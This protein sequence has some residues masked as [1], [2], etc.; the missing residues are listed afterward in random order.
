LYP[1]CSFFVLLI[2]FFS[3]QFIGEF[4]VGPLWG[5]DFSSWKIAAVSLITALSTIV[6]LQKRGLTPGDIFK[7][8]R[9]SYIIPE[10]K[11]TEFF[12]ILLIAFSETKFEL[13]IREER[14]E[15]RISRKANL[16]TFGE[17]ILLKKV[18]SNLRLRIRPKYFL[19]LFDQGQAHDSLL[20]ID[21]LLTDYKANV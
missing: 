14:G 1:F 10:L 20:R 21:R 15:I 11:I 18:D 7:Y 6:P 9:R 16:R 19:D 5:E 3:L 13:S 17:T 8:F 2:L 4:L 12:A